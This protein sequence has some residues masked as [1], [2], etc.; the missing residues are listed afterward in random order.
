MEP[1]IAG[2]KS[3]SFLLLLIP[4][5]FLFYCAS[6]L[7][8]EL[9]HLMAALLTSLKPLSLSVGFGKKRTLFSVG[10]VE[11]QL[12]SNLR[13]GMVQA[14]GRTPKYFRSSQF[15]FAMAG[16][17]ASAVVATVLFF[18]CTSIPYSSRFHPWTQ[19]IWFYFFLEC[20]CLAACLWPRM[21]YIDGE[22]LPNDGLLM[23]QAIGM[24]REEIID[25][26]CHQKI[27]LSRWLLK[28][29]RLEEGRREF[30]EASSCGNWQ[31]TDVSKNVF[32]IY[33]LLRTGQIDAARTEQN[34][35]IADK[36]RGSVLDALAC[37]PLYYGYREFIPEALGYIDTALENEPD[38][39]TLKGTKGSLLI[40][41]GSIS[42]GMLLLKEVQE[43]SE[44]PSDQAICAYYIALACSKLGESAEAVRL[45]GD[46]KKKFPQ[47]IVAKRI[48]AEIWKS[49]LEREESLIGA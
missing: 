20:F 34:R 36:A 25:R 14:V 37:L 30:E 38:K 23:L 11:I 19:V 48:E 22:Q 42:P 12:G 43:K 49:P 2:C 18:I 16:P 8:H 13:G 39:I 6:I 17:M 10:D 9:G 28:R 32:W 40:E 45:L 47:C 15:I 46:A 44:E 7:I 33:L 27:F 26:Y 35:L 5:T 41:S 29:Q 4:A 31:M 21:L 24:K 3:C 1:F